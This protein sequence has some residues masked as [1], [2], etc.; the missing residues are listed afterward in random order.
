MSVPYIIGSG[1]LMAHPTGESESDV[2]RLD[3]NRRLMLQFCGSVGYVR[4]GIVGIPR[5]R[6][7]RVQE[8]STEG[9]RSD[10]SENSQISPSTIVRAVRAA[11]SHP[12][13]ESGFQGSGKIATIHASFGVIRGMSDP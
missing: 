2:V 7:S 9:R 13:L 8:Q 4:R 1:E 6:L 12:H 10:A 3:F 11:G 5:V